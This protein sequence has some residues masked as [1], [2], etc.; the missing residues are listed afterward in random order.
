MSSAQCLRERR[1]LGRL[2][3]ST[4]AT[5]IALS[6]RRNNNNKNH[7]KIKP[8]KKRVS[9]A[10]YVEV[11]QEIDDTPNEIADMDMYRFVR[12]ASSLGTASRP[13]SSSS[14]SSRKN[15]SR[16]PYDNILSL[17]TPNP[18][19]AALDKHSASAR[20]N[21]VRRRSY[22]ESMRHRRASTAHDDIDENQIKKRFLQP[23]QSSMNHVALTRQPAPKPRRPMSASDGTVTAAAGAGGGRTGRVLR[24]MSHESLLESMNRAKP[25]GPKPSIDKLFQQY[26]SLDMRSTDPPAK[27]PAADRPRSASIRLSSGGMVSL[28]DFPA[29]PQSSHPG[30]HGN[31]APFGFPGLFPSLRKKKALRESP[32]LL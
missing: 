21:E 11:A 1:G 6:P 16:K 8:P 2:C 3:V 24:S 4:G 9:F 19:I 18:S 25:T 15:T 29:A 23:T 20:N 17:A 31:V 13:S 28:T 32:Y 7:A 30:N 5:Q 10:A 22:D 14:Y 26:L 27:Q 12:P